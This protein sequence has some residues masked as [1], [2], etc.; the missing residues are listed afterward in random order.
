MVN[1]PTEKR[2]TETES[3]YR[4]TGGTGLGIRKKSRRSKPSFQVEVV[5][6]K[7]S[8]ALKNVLRRLGA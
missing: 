5:F 1:S 3:C 7:L 6:T 8:L 2:L 4:P